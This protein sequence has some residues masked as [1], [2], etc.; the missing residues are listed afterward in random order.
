MDEW[1][2]EAGEEVELHGLTKVELNGQ[3][4]TLLPLEFPE[5]AK[6]LGRLAVMLHS[7]KQVAVRVSNLA[8]SPAVDQ[9]G[10]CSD[11]GVQWASLLAERGLRIALPLKSVQ[12]PLRKAG[13]DELPALGFGTTIMPEDFKERVTDKEYRSQVEERTRECLLWALHAGVRL[14]DCANMNINQQAV[15]RALEFAIGEGIVVREDLFIVGR[16][17]R[18]KDQGEVR[19]EV[20]LMLRELQMEH[21]D[22]LALDLPPERAAEVWPWIEE[23]YREGRARFLAA[24]N[25]DLLGPGECVVAFRELMS[26][27][28]IPPSA[29]CMEVHPFNTNVEMAECCRAMHVQVIASSP[30]GAPHKIEA[31][32]KALTK[33]DAREM[34]PLLKLCDNPV[35]LEIAERHGTSVPQVALRWNL[36]R[37]HCV[38]PKSFDPEHISDNVNL[39]GFRLS[40]EDM[41]SIDCLHKGVRADRFFKQAQ[42]NGSKSLPAMNREAREECMAVLRKF[43]GRLEAWPAQEDSKD[44]ARPAFAPQIVGSLPLAPRDPPQGY[45]SRTD[46]R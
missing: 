23:I 2:F 19:R 25:F 24:S 36:Q 12:L 27:T 3:R 16:V 1:G 7:G 17:W 40:N 15:G 6:A 37:G 26:K 21:V 30:L 14:F 38:L 4:G 42:K 8:K 5:Q 45:N 9:A 10:L 29:Y 20:D 32:M 33:S 11:R 44:Q 41:M 22:L 35:M 43:R 28:E 18:C 46:S 39:F 13:L 31:F 34:R